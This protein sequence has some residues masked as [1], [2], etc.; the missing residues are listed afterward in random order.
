MADRPTMGG[1]KAVR[2]RVA[3]EACGRCPSLTPNSQPPTLNFYPHLLESSG[4]ASFQGGIGM[5]SGWVRDAEGRVI[6]INGTA[7]SAGYGAERT[8]TEEMCE[9][10]DNGFGLFVQPKPFGGREAWC[11]GAGRWGVVLGRAVVRVTALG[12]EF[13]KD[14]VGSCEVADF[15][16]PGEG[17]T[18]EWQESSQNFAITNVE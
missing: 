4:A 8:D 9:S 2:G 6:G 10:T 7:Q 13:A 5:G 12:E 15:P 11:G 18:P 3:G 14:V 17:V 1:L 16:S